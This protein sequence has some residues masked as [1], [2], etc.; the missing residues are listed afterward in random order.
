MQSKF[1]GHS[2]VIIFS[3]THI[4]T[5]MSLYYVMYVYLGGGGGAKVKQP[6]RHECQT[7]QF[8]WWEVRE[9]ER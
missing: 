7:E 6:W 5:N 9:G 8:G 3:T 4:H 2:Q 1:S